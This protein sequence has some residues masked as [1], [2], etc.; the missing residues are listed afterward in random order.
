MKV[1]DL[2]SKND[3]VT[4]LLIEDGNEDYKL[5]KGPKGVRMLPV[6]LEKRTSVPDNVIEP[7]ST[8]WSYDVYPLAKGRDAYWE[9]WDH[10]QEK[11]G[12]FEVVSPER[13]VGR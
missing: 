12:D 8:K 1:S 3:I 2:D 7:H 13:M 9:E 10:F 4:H 6:D 11:Y 5:G